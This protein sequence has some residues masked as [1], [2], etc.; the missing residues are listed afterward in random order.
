MFHIN[1]FGSMIEHAG[2]KNGLGFQCVSSLSETLDFL[3]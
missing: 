3:L 1:I 2:F